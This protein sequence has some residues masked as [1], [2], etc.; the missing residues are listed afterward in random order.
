MKSFLSHIL[1]LN[2]L[3]IVTACSKEETDAMLSNYAS[4]QALSSDVT[5]S[6][7]ETNA[8]RTYDQTPYKPKKKEFTLY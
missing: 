6:M 8:Y 4:D 2:L 5:L 3:L 1:L 7:M